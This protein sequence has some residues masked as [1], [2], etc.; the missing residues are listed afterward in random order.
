[1]LPHAVVLSMK[2]LKMMACFEAEIVAML[3]LCSRVGN[4]VFFFGCF[5]Q[6]CKKE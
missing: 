6:A 1:M 5:L 2:L 4:P 3:E